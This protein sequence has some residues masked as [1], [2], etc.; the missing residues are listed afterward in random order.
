MS[1]RED[2]AT[3]EAEAWTVL[4]ERPDAGD[5]AYGWSVA[6]TVGHIAYWTDRTASILEAIDHGDP[7]Q[8]KSVEVDEENARLMPSWS[9]PP[10]RKLEPISSGHARGSSPPGPG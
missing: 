9:P 5:V 1:R 3:R 6:A 2:L 4:L 7:S 8:I 10:S